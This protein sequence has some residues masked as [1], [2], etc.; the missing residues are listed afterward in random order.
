MTVALSRARL[1]LYILGRRDV[2][3]AC[4]ELRP[5]FEQLLQRP[6][7]L[8]L[9]TG[10][11]WPSQRLIASESGEVPGEACMEGV[12]HLGQFVY[13]MTNTKVKQLEAEQN[14]GGAGLMAIEEAPAEEAGDE[15]AGEGD[16]ESA[17]AGTEG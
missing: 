13:Q 7:K 12:E 10:E 2:F 11:M 3:E 5:A 16:P 17:A 15:E 8:M 1:G 4:Y 6:D 9:V 14:P